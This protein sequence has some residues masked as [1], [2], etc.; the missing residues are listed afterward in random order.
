MRKILVN[1]HVTAITT[2]L[3]LCGNVTFIVHLAI[4]KGPTLTTITHA[5]MV[6][7]IFM[8][9]A[10]L[11]NTSHNKERILESGWK[12]VF[13]NIFVNSKIAKAEIERSAKQT[14]ELLSSANVQKNHNNKEIFMT[15]SSKNEACST[16]VNDA[17][18]EAM[19]HAPDNGDPDFERGETSKNS[20]NSNCKL[21]DVND[22]D[23]RQIGRAQV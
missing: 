14:S 1:A 7:L 19:V 8:P 2:F 5:M 22:L 18:D 12:N 23:Y 16:I 9:Y 4:T 11:M 10:F 17:N 21:L 6:K 15:T 13:R 3:E 20:M